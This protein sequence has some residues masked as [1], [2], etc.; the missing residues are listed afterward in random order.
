[1]LQIEHI[2]KTYGPDRVLDAVDVEAPAGVTLS[3]LG[4]SGS[5]KTT[6]LVIAAGLVPPDSGAVKLDGRDVTRL[7]PEKRG[8]VYLHQEALLFPHLDVLDNVAFGLRVRG[9]RG[10][11]VEDRAEE[12]LR[13]LGL[14]DHARKKP[15]QLSGGQKQ[16]VAFGRALIVAPRVLLLD[17]PFGALDG[18]TRTEMQELFARVIH[19]REMTTVFVT[20]DLKEALRVGDRFAVIEGGV[21]TAYERRRDFLDHPNVTAREELEFWREILNE[22]EV[23][24]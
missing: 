2:S 24:T 21:L 17:E 12:M 6:L 20:H 8:M 3:V 4:E 5:G 22:R 9:L 10:A 18:R 13:D 7:P 23:T 19:E 14:L 16:R 1:M 15:P 11:E